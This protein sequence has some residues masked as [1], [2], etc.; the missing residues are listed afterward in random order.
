M[1]AFFAVPSAGHRANCNYALIFSQRYLKAWVIKV[2][3][4]SMQNFVVI[5]I[6]HF[7]AFKLIDTL[8]TVRPA[9][10]I[11]LYHSHLLAFF[12]EELFGYVATSTLR[13]LSVYKNEVANWLVCIYVYPSQIVVE[14]LL[15]FRGI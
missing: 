14:V 10:I 1:V 7:E 11:E 6:K 13:A 2:P 9:V 15:C 3:I 5:L 12:T 8:F 4:L